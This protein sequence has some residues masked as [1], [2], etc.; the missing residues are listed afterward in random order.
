MRLPSFSTMAEDYVKLIWKAGERGG[1]G[2]ATRDIAATLKV[3]V[4]KVKSDI[5]R[6]RQALRAALRRDPS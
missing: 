5:F 2:L 3:S 4:A 6:A 1:A